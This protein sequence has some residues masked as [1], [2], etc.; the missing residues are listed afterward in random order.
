ML[1]SR[2]LWIV[3]LIVQRIK[4]NADRGLGN[5]SGNAHARIRREA[6]RAKIIITAKT[7]GDGGLI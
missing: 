6:Q 2:D 1:S 7:G 4:E 5:F 3:L